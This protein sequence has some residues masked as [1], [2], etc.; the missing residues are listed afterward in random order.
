MLEGSAAAT[1]VLA[2]EFCPL[3]AWDS[4][5]FATGIVAFTETLGFGDS[6]VFIDCNK[7]GGGAV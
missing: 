4:E 3:V 7:F 2:V 1:E 5:T 6:V